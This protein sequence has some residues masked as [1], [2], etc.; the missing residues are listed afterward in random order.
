MN[1]LQKIEKQELRA[2]SF[3]GGSDRTY[4]Q[5]KLIIDLLQNSLSQGKAITRDDIL[6]CYLDF[7]YGQKRSIYKFGGWKWSP[8]YNREV[9]TR[10]A[11]DREEAKTVYGA[12]IQAI[13][14]FK[15]NLGAAILK[16]KV[17]AIPVIDLDNND[18]NVQA[19]VA[20]KD[21]QRTEPR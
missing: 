9:E 3:S 11:V 17:L 14:W 18:R 4:V 16:G 13:Q 19:S 7:V 10:V 5:T 6:N 21:D 20:S 1:E 8:Y 12:K 15:S 2:A